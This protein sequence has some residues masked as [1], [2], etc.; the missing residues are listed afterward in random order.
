M[1]EVNF[2][3]LDELH[4]VASLKNN[5]LLRD[6]YL[7]G[8]PCAAHWDQLEKGHYRDYVI[9]TLPQLNDLDGT[10][11]SRAERIKAMQRL[12]EL[13]RELAS[14]APLAK[15][16]KQELRERRK[17]KQRKIDAGEIVVDNE[18]TDE[19]CPEVRVSDARELRE[20]D[21]EKEAVRE[22]SRRGGPGD[23]LFS[24]QP[25]RERRFF[26][27]DGT[28]IQMNT[29]KWPFSI[30]EDGLNVYVDVALPRFLDSNVV[31]TRARARAPRAVACAHAHARTRTR[32]PTHPRARAH[33]RTHG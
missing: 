33:P 7:M 20:I 9:A 24:D 10:K 13:E 32:A 2:I 4:T 15:Q 5:S 22:K 3:D 23:L 12:P 30:D 17:E 18:T 31:S 26:R 29:A 21:L 27:D 8:N 25:K 1:G 6:F 16:R 11:V 19:W 14:L 28:P